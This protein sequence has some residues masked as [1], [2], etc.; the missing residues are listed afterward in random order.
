VKI[1]E[2]RSIYVQG[3]GK[4]RGNLRFPLAGQ[5][6]LGLKTP[7]VCSIPFEC[8]QIHIQQAAHLTLASLTHALNVWTDDLRWST[9]SNMGHQKQ[10]Q[11]TSIL[12]TKSRCMECIIREVIQ[13]EL[14]LYNIG[15]GGWLLFK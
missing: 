14:H 5:G 13:I 15:L 8:S 4:G 1:D 2:E 10:L 12:F 11:D 7:G 9:A 3:Q 6:V